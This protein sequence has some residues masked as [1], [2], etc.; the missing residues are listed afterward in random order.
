MREKKTEKK[1]EGKS[2]GECGK[3]EKRGLKRR[4]EMRDWGHWDIGEG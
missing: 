4:E 3:W 2:G 1:S